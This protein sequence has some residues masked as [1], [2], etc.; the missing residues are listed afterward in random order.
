MNHKEALGLLL[1]LTLLVVPES[2]A[3]DRTCQVLSADGG[4]VIL[5]CPERQDLQSDDWVRLRVVKK[6][7]VEG[8]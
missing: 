3:K 1:L 8:C 7:L 4:R 5:Q 2:R 6:K